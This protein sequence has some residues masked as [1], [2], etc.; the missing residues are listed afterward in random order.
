MQNAESTEPQP[1]SAHEN[2]NIRLPADDGGSSGPEPSSEIKATT[3]V[4]LCRQPSPHIRIDCTAHNV[5][6]GEHVRSATAQ[7]RLEGIDPYGNAQSV[8]KFDLIDGSGRILGEE[9]D[10]QQNSKYLSFLYTGAV[11][12]GVD[13]IPSDWPANVQESV[14]CLARYREDVFARIAL[15]NLVK[16]SGLDVVRYIRGYNMCNG[17]EPPWNLNPHELWKQLEK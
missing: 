5:L 14:N 16:V 15:T 1:A 6:S 2:V 11:V 12:P 4:E 13:H 17:R 7:F 8:S 9:T 10:E 3:T